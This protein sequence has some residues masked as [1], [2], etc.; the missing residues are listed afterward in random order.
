MSY[1]TVFKTPGKERDEDVVRHERFGNACC[2][3][4]GVRKRR[5]SL[6]KTESSTLASLSDYVLSG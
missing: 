1:S 4:P 6:E 5:R 3:W 2:E